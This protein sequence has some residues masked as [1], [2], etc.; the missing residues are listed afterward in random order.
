M[1]KITP[2]NLDDLAK[3]SKSIILDGVR[4]D[5]RELTVQE[6]IDRAAEARKLAEQAEAPAEDPTKWPVEKQIEKL[7]EM[8]HDA[9]PTV[10]KERLGKLHLVQLNAVLDLTMKTP[11]QVAQSVEQGNG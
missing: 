6:F 4:H 10:S 2:L 9:F 11:E 1:T 7:V 3:P 5:M 8:I